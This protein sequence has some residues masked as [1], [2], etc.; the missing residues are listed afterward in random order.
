MIIIYYCI[1]KLLF[2]ALLQILDITDNKLL[3]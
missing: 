3:G 2:Y 1:F